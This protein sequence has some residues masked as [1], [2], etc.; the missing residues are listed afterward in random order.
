MSSG[1]SAQP[2][3]AVYT[4]EEWAEKMRISRS[5]AYN[6]VKNGDV[7]VIRIGKLIR[8]PASAVPLA[9]AS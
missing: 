4:V 5:A 8:I 2:K 7:A 3:P 6:A 9:A 1:S